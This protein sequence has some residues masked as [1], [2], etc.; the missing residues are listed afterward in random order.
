MIC[1]KTMTQAKLINHQQDRVWMNK[2]SQRRHVNFV[3]PFATWGVCSEFF[4]RLE[5]IKFTT[6]LICKSFGSTV[7]F[8]LFRR[9]AAVALAKIKRV[10]QVAQSVDLLRCRATNLCTW[11]ELKRDIQRMSLRYVCWLVFCANELGMQISERYQMFIEF[12]YKL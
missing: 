12:T 2:L 3:T 9:S 1:N 4:A 10:K 7:R 8:T 5:T 6:Q 11:F